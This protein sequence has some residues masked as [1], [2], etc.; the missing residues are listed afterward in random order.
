MYEFSGFDYDLPSLNLIGE[1]KSE[2]CTLK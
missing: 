1:F 2:M